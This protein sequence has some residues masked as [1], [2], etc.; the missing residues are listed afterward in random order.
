M[1]INLPHQYQ[2]VN[3]HGGVQPSKPLPGSVHLPHTAM[4]EPQRRQPRAHSALDDEQRR[5]AFGVGGPA[6]HAEAHRHEHER[7][8]EVY[9]G[10]AAQ[11]V[12]GH[13]LL[14][15]VRP[16]EA[17]RCRGRAEQHRAEKDA[18]NGERGTADAKAPDNSSDVSITRSR[19]T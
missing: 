17:E 16:D 12:P 8:E 11:H 19:G 6:N 15:R 10:G 13:H 1:A 2:P 5:R 9:A 7:P 4:Q 14:K 18:R 3:D